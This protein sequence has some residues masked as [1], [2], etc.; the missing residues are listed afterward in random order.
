MFMVRSRT[1]TPSSGPVTARSSTKNLSLRSILVPTRELPVVHCS[2]GCVGVLQP[3]AF[4]TPLSQ[5]ELLHLARRRLRQRSEDDLLRYFE[6]SDVPAD[7][8]DQLVG[9]HLLSGPQRHERDRHLA[10][11]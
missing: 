3:S 2:P 9:G 6:A 10:P 4:T 7:V 5:N 11:A 8:F 1:R